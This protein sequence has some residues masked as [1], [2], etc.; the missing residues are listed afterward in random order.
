M[1]H[2]PLDPAG[3]PFG[4]PA[5]S[6]NVYC[7]HCQQE[8]DSYRIE[9]RIKTCR[10]GKP[11]GFWSCPIPNCDGAG[12]GFDIFPTDREWTFEDGEKIWCSGDEYEEDEEL[13]DDDGP[14]DAAGEADKQPPQD[15]DIPW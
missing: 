7:L 13:L 4:P 11:H 9:W 5:I 2:D 1:S 12:F 6:T 14:A 10:D 8:Y 15:E 3:D